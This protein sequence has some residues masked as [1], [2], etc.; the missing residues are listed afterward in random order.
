M[1]RAARFITDSVA[2]AALAVAAYVLLTLAAATF[3]PDALAQS[4][5]AFFVESDNA[6]N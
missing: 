6:Q 2:L 5:S 4:R 1:K 3:Q